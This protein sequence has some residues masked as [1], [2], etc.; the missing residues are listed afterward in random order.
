MRNFSRFMAAA[1][2][3]ACAASLAFALDQQT[4]KGKTLSVKAATRQRKVTASGKEKQAQRS[5]GNPTTAGSRRR[6]PD[7]L[8]ERRQCRG[9]SFVLP[10]GNSPSTGKAFGRSAQP[11][12]Q[13]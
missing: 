13:A 11:R 8:R 2:G 7:D 4:V 12:I 5:F 10:S 3:L 1:V 6:H 9:G